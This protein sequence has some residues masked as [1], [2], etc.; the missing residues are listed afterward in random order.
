M[1]PFTAL[2]FAQITL[3]AFVAGLNAG[4][5]FTTWPRMGPSWLPNG[6]TSLSPIWT[7]LVD[8]P[9]AVQFV[10][11]W[12]AVAVAVFAL[13]VA[14]RLRRAGATAHAVALGSAV[15]LQFLLGVMTLVQAVPVAVAVAH[16]AGAGLLLAVTVV[17]GHW[18]MGGAPRH[19]TERCPQQIQD[20][21][22]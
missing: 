12:L 1:W 4:Y 16:Q 20:D 22:D 5:L 7:N 14:A 21:L 3:G 11:R 9:V 13:L 19:R 15:L 17:A 18:S 2:L 6:L 8:N 10:H